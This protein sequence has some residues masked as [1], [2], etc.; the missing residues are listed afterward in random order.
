MTF[1]SIEIINKLPNPDELPATYAIALTQFNAISLTG[2]DKSTYLQGQ[3]TCDVN[4]VKEQSMSRGAH[5][6]AKGKV[7]A[8]FRLINRDDALLL[9]QPKSSLSASLAALKKFG[10]FAK[11]TIE[12]SEDYKFFALVGEQASD[13]IHQYYDAVPDS[14]TPVIHQGATSIIYLSGKQSRYLIVQ[15]KTQDNALM[16]QCQLPIY[17]DNVW[18]LTE[19]Q[20]GFPLLEENSLEQYVPQM[21]N[22]Q[23][24]NGISFTK[25]CYL[26]QETVARMQYLGKN[27]RALY[28]LTSNALDET[29]TIEIS[30][31]DIIEKQLGDNWRKAGDILAAYVGPNKISLQAVLANDVDQNTQFR[32]KNQPNQTF[33]LTEL[34]YSINPEN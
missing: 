12:E 6:D 31:G 33:T 32:L 27:K 13:L 7:Y 14:L 4:L 10:V 23:A 5:C 19:I 11:V 20:E 2:E 21:L 9:L 29:S 18:Q 16:A 1:M 17:N 15:Q 28:G 24:I 8:I 22:L 34:P 25:G 26:G 3:V 30:S